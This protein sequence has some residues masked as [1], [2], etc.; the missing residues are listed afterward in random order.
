MHL[1]MQFSYALS[2]LIVLAT[3]ALA[4][5]KLHRFWAL[6]LGIAALLAVMVADSRDHPR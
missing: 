2:I 1:G 3:F 4:A 6:L 5:T